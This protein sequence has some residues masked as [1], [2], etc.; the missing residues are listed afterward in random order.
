MHKYCRSQVLQSSSEKGKNTSGEVIESLQS[1]YPPN[2]TSGFGSQVGRALASNAS[3]RQIRIN[4][5]NGWL[6]F[7]FMGQI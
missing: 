5:E 7:I 2:V 6:N 4:D 1:Q 3:T